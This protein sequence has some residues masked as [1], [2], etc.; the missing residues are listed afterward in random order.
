MEGRLFFSTVKIQVGK[1]FIDGGPERGELE[2]QVQGKF[3][4]TLYPLIV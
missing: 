2:K 1:A 3:H 4:K